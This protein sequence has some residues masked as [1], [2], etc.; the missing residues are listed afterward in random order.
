MLG[1]FPKSFKKSKKIWPE[2][3]LPCQPL[4]Y[5]D[6]SNLDLYYQLLRCW[7]SQKQEVSV[8]RRLLKSKE[9]NSKPLLSNVNH[10]MYS[11]PLLSYWCHFELYK[12]F[13]FNKAM[14]TLVVNTDPARIALLLHKNPSDTSN[15]TFCC[16]RQFHD[17]TRAIGQRWALKCKKMNCG[18]LDGTLTRLPDVGI[19]PSIYGRVPGWRTAHARTKGGFGC[20]PG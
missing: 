1:K 15:V 14:E 18:S 11:V 16:K 20:S 10:W 19:F 4:A 7:E 17:T 6:L 5:Y 2:V 8:D 3:T 9:G 13:F 12:F